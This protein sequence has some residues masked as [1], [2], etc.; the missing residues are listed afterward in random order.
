MRARG[1][2]WVDGLVSPASDVR[3]CFGAS[4]AYHRYKYIEAHVHTWRRQ[5]VRAALA[6]QATS[7]SSMVVASTRPPLPVAPRLAPWQPHGDAPLARG[8]IPCPTPAH[9]PR[10]QRLGAGHSKGRPS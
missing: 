4:S 6:G 2:A 8:R 1:A 7:A 5:A 9:P 3:A 10:S